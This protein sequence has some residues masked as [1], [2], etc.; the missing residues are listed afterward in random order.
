MKV[1]LIDID[2]TLIDSLERTKAIAESI[3]ECEIRMGD[4]LNLDLEQI[5]FKYTDN[6]QKSHTN[7]LRQLFRDTLLYKNRT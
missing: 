3:L 4:M 2:D 5:F 6:S 1:I 7:E